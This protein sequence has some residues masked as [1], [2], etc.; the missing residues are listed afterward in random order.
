[1]GKK[2]T[3]KQEY[4]GDFWLESEPARRVP[5][6]LTFHPVRGGELLLHS[7]LHA[8]ARTMAH[9]K[10]DRILGKV[11]GRS[12]VLL[13]CFDSGRSTSETGPGEWEV[14]ARIF[15]N[16]MLLVPRQHADSPAERF[17]A[18]GASFRGLPEFDGRMPFQHERN[19][20]DDV[21]TQR[22]AVVGLEPRTVQMDRATIEFLQGTGSKG[23]DFKSETLLSSHSMRVTPREVLPLHELI[24]LY[25]RAR[26]L[27][28]LAMHQDCRFNGPI[29]LQPEDRADD[30]DPDDPYTRPYEYHAVWLRGRRHSFE[31]YNRVLSYEALGP[32]GIARWLALEDEC[33]HVISRLSSLRYTRRLAYEDALLRVVAAADSLHRVVTGEDW[34]K[35][36][37]MLKELAEYARYPFR[38]AV[39]DLDKWAHAII[40]E[41]DNAAHNKGR[42][43]YK[44][45]FPTQLVESVYLL[46]LVCLLRRADAPESA[47]ESVRHRQ[48]FVWPMKDIFNEF[49]GDDWVF[50]MGNSRG[51]LGG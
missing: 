24:D 47:F 1:V 12:C 48:P 51:T 18:A 28:A 46:V 25:S 30:S 32:D 37:T 40:N 45:A 31:L 43:I 49:G 41:R 4:W 10:Y 27:V 20:E 11:L 14:N 38:T 22:A 23:R 19:D 50:R 16:G 15:V 36:R 2:K 7:T 21:M 3:K 44:P 6:H 42:P 33:G 39:P 29:Y 26:T 35:S 13:D 8:N 5:G 9:D 17:A 34:T